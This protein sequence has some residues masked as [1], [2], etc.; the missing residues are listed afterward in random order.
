[1]IPPKDCD[2]Q[3]FK[4]NLIH[5]AAKLPTRMTVGSA[6]WDLYAVENIE[7]PPT[8]S[9]VNGQVDVGRALIPIGIKLGLPSG[10]V[11]R[12][13]SRSGLSV[14]SNLEVGAGW[15]D[16][17]YRGELNVELKNLSSKPFMVKVGDRIAQLVILPIVDIKIEAVVSLKKTDRNSSGFGS[18]DFK[19]EK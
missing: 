11:G 1:M 5:P 6:G 4:V 9:N 2:V 8:T 19:Q 14:K 3:I 17:D 16:S 12:I 7:V 10:T 18:T 15:I 13:A